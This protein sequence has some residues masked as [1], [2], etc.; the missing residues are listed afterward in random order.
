M[1]AR[2]GLG[3]LA[4]GKVPYIF[5]HAAAGSFVRLGLM[6]AN[7][8]VLTTPSRPIQLHNWY[9]LSVDQYALPGSNSGCSLERLHCVVQQR[10]SRGTV[11][12]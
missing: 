9:L 10:L 4:Y 8:K 6:I 3:V 11:E 7:G 5:T 2:N 12:V 1:Y